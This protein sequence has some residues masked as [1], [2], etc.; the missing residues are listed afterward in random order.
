MALNINDRGSE[1]RGSTEG[2]V[3]RPGTRRARSVESVPNSRENLSDIGGSDGQKY[4]Y[5]VQLA[6]QDLGDDASDDEDFRNLVDEYYAQMDPTASAEDMRGETGVTRAIRGIG[7]FYDGVNDTLG[8]GID[9]L[10]DNVIGSAAGGIGSVV[11]AASNGQTNFEEEWR[12]GVSDAISPAT[13]DAIA[14]MGTGMLV[15]AI[16]GLGI[17]LSI[18][19]T[20]AQNSDDIYEAITGRDAISLE[21]LDGN[22]RLGRAGAALLDTALA[23]APAVG[24]GVRYM[25]GGQYLDDIAD[26]SRAA[27][28]AGN[29]KEADRLLDTFVNMG[30]GTTSVDR[31]TDALK[32]VTGKSSKEAAKEGS[33][34]I[35]GAIKSVMK[36]TS[37]SA[38]NPVN[39]VGQLADSVRSVGRKGVVTPMMRRANA[40]SIGDQAARI[41]SKSAANGAK[42]AAKGGLA[43][44]AKSLGKSAA[45]NAGGAI[46]RLASNAGTGGLLNYLN[47]MGQTGDASLG[48]WGQQVGNPANVMMMVAPSA[49][50]GI[51][52]ANRMYGKL[53][54]SGLGGQGAAGSVRARGVGN[55]V[56]PVEQQPLDDDELRRRIKWQG[57]R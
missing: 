53:G 36:R 13:A 18:G 3:S 50:R 25:R 32:A 11:D 52:G 14:S 38:L 27:R 16:P 23:A 29:T 22:E 21:E 17:P 56:Q 41:A 15:S 20:A 8:D 7:E 12:R 33:K 37:G 19:L 10:W 28:A 40:L 45:R 4:Q 49:L 34:G 42:K 48:G 5:A 44:G 6:R 55:N 24:K 1:D 46:A 57:M 31:A 51:P 2:K 35:G 30:L 43:E 26:A 54:L 9:W 39:Q 47:Y